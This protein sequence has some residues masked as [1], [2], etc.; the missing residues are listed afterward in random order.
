MSVT[1]NAENR[2]VRWERLYWSAINYLGDEPYEE[3]QDMAC[4]WE[5]CCEKE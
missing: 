1:Y 5:E 4:E 3:A 2:P